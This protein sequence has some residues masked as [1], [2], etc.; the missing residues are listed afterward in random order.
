[1]NEG[2]F[3]RCRPI[4]FR[5]R[6]CVSPAWT[7][8]YKTGDSLDGDKMKKGINKGV[9]RDGWERKLDLGKRRVGLSLLIKQN[10]G[11]ILMYH[12]SKKGPRT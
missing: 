7:S 12:L 11:G 6:D 3:P 2:S 8:L 4:P 10:V 5:V 9:R 1:M